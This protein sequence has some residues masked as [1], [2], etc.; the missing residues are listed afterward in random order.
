MKLDV[1]TIPIEYGYNSQEDNI[2]LSLN[3]TKLLKYKMFDQSLEEYDIS[4][5]KYN[6]YDNKYKHISNQLLEDRFK[7]KKLKMSYSS[8]KSYFQCPFLYFADRI[9]GLNEFK[10]SMAARLGTFSHAVLEDSYNADFSFSESVDRNTKLNALDAKD[11]F[12]FKMME[13]VLSSLIEFNHL[14]EQDSQLKQIKRELHI[15]LVEDPEDLLINIPILM[16]LRQFETAGTE[17]CG[18]S[19]L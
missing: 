15:E 1:K 2:R 16:D 5:L 12:Y 18:G 19:S 8:I 10:P 7:V 4:H 14:H 6:S 17:K 3:Y 13:E 11:R 9:L